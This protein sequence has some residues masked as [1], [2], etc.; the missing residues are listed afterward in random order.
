MIWP[1]GDPV[2]LTYSPGFDGLPSLSK[3]GEKMLFARSASGRD[4][5]ATYI[6]DMTS[7]DL[8]PDAY[9]GIPDTVKPADP[10]FVTDFNVEQ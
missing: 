5:L 1:G 4:N 7:F 8:G 10:V 9:K 3:N 6:M 2:R